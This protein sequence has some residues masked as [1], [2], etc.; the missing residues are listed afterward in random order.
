MTKLFPTII[1][2]KALSAIYKNGG[3]DAVDGFADLV[4]RPDVVT[5]HQVEAETVDVV[6]ADPVFHRLD[7]E[8][9][10]HGLIGGR[11]VATAGAVGIRGE[12]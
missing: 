3:I 2:Q 10:H 7:H 1:N 9:P 11:L 12:R 5:T 6:F 4:H 8:L